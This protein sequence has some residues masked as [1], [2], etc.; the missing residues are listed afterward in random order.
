LS[1]L[2]VAEKAVDPK[3]NTTTKVYD[4]VGNKAIEKVT[5]NGTLIK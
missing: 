5:F 3:D 1:K 4:R 2:A